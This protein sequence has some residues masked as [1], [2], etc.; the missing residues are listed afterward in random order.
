MLL[1]PRLFRKKVLKFFVTA[2][3]LG[4]LMAQAQSDFEVP[5][6]W[7]KSPVIITDQNSSYSYL[8]GEKDKTVEVARQEKVGVLINSDKGAK[9]FKY[10]YFPKEFDA[11]IQ[12][13]SASDSDESYDQDDA[14]DLSV[15]EEIPFFFAELFKGYTEF[16]KVLLGELGKGDEISIT[17]NYQESMVTKE[18]MGGAS[19]KSFMGQVI[20]FPSIYPK[21]G[22]NVSI[23]MDSRMYINYG[24]MA[25]GPY[26]SDES[27]LEA[28]TSKFE[29]KSGQQDAYRKQLFTYPARM[30]A[31]SKFEVI[32]CGKNDPSDGDLLAGE[33]PG[34]AYEE[35][36]EEVLKNAIYNKVSS[37]KKQYS[38]TAGNLEDFLGELRIKGVES[39]I[40]QHYRGF[41]SYVYNTG[42][43]EGYS[44]DMFMGVM[45]NLLDDA[46]YPYE[47]LVG[48]DRRSASLDDM[49]LNG[50]LRFGI[51]VEDKKDDFTFYPFTKYTTWTDKD[52]LMSGNEA[53]IYKHNKKLDDVSF[54][55][56]DLPDGT[57]ASNQKVVRSTLK[58]ADGFTAVLV[59][60]NTNLSGEEKSAVAPN[61]VSIPDYHKAT[62]DKAKFQQYAD[63]RDEDETEDFKNG[64]KGL[65]EAQARSMFDTVEF[66]RFNVK[67]TGF[68]DDNDWLALNE[69]YI[70]PEE[71]IDFQI[72]DSLRVYTVSLGAFI[73]S[74]LNVSKEDFKRDGEIFVGYPRIMDTRLRL[75]VPPGYAVFG[76]DAFDTDMKGDFGSLKVS[77]TQKGKEIVVS[78]SM[79]I[80]TTDIKEGD[81]QQL[82]SMLSRLQKLS[83]VT[84]TLAGN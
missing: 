13:T 80:K 49:V 31:T 39:W 65:Y 23:E 67:K 81:W 30:Y 15:G 83:E 9:D 38:K 36:D 69:K 28:A 8:M 37:L 14:R 1:A 51:R 63:L 60:K 34:Q 35:F 17:Y 45:M 42:E 66:Q 26:L 59:N 21:G 46:E 84:V 62:L 19:C 64:R 68:E 44:P 27:E 12:L 29:I 79:V 74:D 3:L 75:V 56:D 76:Y 10:V 70:I 47:L 33:T 61:V 16:E 7:A 5:G 53:F 72:K 54:E 82:Y 2:V 77:A 52:Y 40:E 4:P 22:H 50:E 41:Q 20:T 25:D 18:F 57:P 55:I 43:V 6:K 58:L 11:E 48:A 71:V 78:C 73:E 24:T 32:Y